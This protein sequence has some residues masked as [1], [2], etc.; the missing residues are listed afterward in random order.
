MKLCFVLS[1]LVATAGGRKTEST[2]NP[3]DFLRQLYA[4]KRNGQTALQDRRMEESNRH[5]RLG[6]PDL[7]KL[8][9]EVKSATPRRLGASKKDLGKPL[10]DEE[11]AQMV[12]GLTPVSGK[13]RDNF[14]GGQNEHE[15]ATLCDFCGQDGWFRDHK[16]L[17]GNKFSVKVTRTQGDYN[18]MVAFC[19]APEFRETTC[20]YSP[21]NIQPDYIRAKENK[22][23]AYADCTDNFNSNKCCNYIY[24]REKSEFKEFLG[25]EGC[26]PE[27][28]KFVER[29]CYSDS[30]EFFECPIGSKMLICK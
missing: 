10:S 14:P 16:P 28:C 18:A 6:G 17:V 11:V 23:E 7:G 1:L 5:R 19:I 12:A 26:S 21:N 3:E 27:T 4:S 9:S 20:V 13:V 25:S 15:D 8:Q 30:E 29:V 2:V 22:T 24:S